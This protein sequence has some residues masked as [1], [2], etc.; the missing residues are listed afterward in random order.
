[1]AAGPGRRTTAETGPTGWSGGA[2][3]GGA[4][5]VAVVV[6]VVIVRARGAACTCPDAAGNRW[7]GGRRGAADSL[8]AL[9]APVV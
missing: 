1:M 5:G 9:A 3:A 8:G 6:I 2:G 7:P 4:A